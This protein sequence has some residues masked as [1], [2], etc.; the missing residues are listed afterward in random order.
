MLLKYYLVTLLTA[1]LLLGCQQ[2][3]PDNK[4]A[5]SILA[6]KKRAVSYAAEQ[7]YDLAILCIDSA[8]TA[9]PKNIEL[10]NTK[11]NILLRSK[12]YTDGLAVL[13]QM[14]K[15]EA[16]NAEAYSFQGYINEKLGN[17]SLATTFY[18]KAIAACKYRANIKVE[19]FKNKV[20]I[21]FLKQ[22]TE[23]KVASIAYIDSLA[24][25]HA[26]NGFIRDQKEFIK[27]FD[28]EAFLK[29]L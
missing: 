9:Q 1:M 3:V 19:E 10:Y 8:L 5:N 6:T 12:K 13:E 2:K 22:F 11:F 18:N 29:A 28:K 15:I 17:D 26:G 4:A 14:H 16:N 20:N 24:I 7:K 27:N 23:G 21:S 25:R